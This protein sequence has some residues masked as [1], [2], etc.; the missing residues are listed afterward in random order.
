[1]KSSEIRQKY[2]KYFEGKKHAI[3]P[4]SSLVPDDPSML[5]TTAGMVQFKPYFLGIEKTPYTRI[6]TAQKCL[7]TTDVD[8]VGLTARHLTFFE[9]LGN[10]SF[11]DYY[12]KE[13]ITW[14]WELLTEVFKLDK[15]RLWPTVYVDDDEAFDIWHNVVGVPES[16]IGR[17]KEDNFWSAGPTGPCGPCSEVI[18]D[19]GEEYSCGKDCVIGCDCDRWLEVWNLVFMQSDRDEKG[20]LTDLPKKNIDTGMGLE[21]ISAIL[22]NAK[23]NFETDLL[24]PLVKKI[25]KISGVEYGAG[26]K[27]DISIK[28]VADHSR[29]TAF[30][31]ADGVIPSNDG[32]GYVLRRLIRRA[33]RHGRILGI[34]KPFIVEMLKEVTKMMGSQY[35]ELI[36]HKE[37]LEKIAGTEEQ[38]FLITLKQGLGLLEGKIRELKSKGKKILSGTE[39]FDLYDTY[40]FPVEL[41]REII[42]EENLSIDMKGY[43]KLMEAQKE[44]ARKAWKGKELELEEAYTE[45]FDLVGNTEFIGYKETETEAEVK[46]IVKGKGLSDKAKEGEEVEII[47][48]KTPFYAEKG[49]Q[50]G[51]TGLIS[52]K[53]G[54]FKVTDTKNP[55]SEMIVH[56]G[57]IAVGEVGIGQAARLEIDKERR[58]SIARAHT[59]THL[60]QW[61]LRAV[62][63]EHVKQAGSM[64]EADRLRFDFSH[65]KALTSKEL[66]KVEGL[67]NSR[68]LSSYPVRCYVTTIDYAKE[69]GATALFGE[70]YGKF[71]RVV[72]AGDFSKELCGGTHIKNTG[73]INLFKISSESSIGANIRRIEAVTGRKVLDILQ[74]DEKTI[75]QLANVLKSTPEQVTVKTESLVK[76]LKEKEKEA[77]KVETGD[78]STTVK[79]LAQKAKKV[80]GVAIASAYFK[81]LSLDVLRS[82]T[83]ALRNQLGSSAVI[84]AGGN[85]G[86]VMLITAASK[87]LVEKGFDASVWL[88]KVAPIVKGRGGGKPSLAQAGGTD[89]SKINDALKEAEKFIEQ[90]SKENA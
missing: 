5:L 43:E 49:G 84:L 23:T 8:S 68:I 50:I 19:F 35:P 90:W 64:V 54:V 36:E 69:I 17:L 12:K 39:V 10:F 74:R 3:L 27:T 57:K 24:Y 31:I 56:K 6:T 13:A 33:V 4:S 82:Y 70:K 55:L 87:D 81:G 2:L 65:F 51:D 86:K 42:E 79:E 9:M 77:K 78:F 40:G 21:R 34:E 72:E 47:V 7:R 59:A 76:K 15:K 1:M 11:G 44:K 89:P 28:V 30:L 18:Y 20:K 41:T 66:A 60:L 22:Q 67:V 45:S 85:D 88:N 26:G 29:A 83:D 25:A 52:T 53:T 71:V 73:L 46:A 16:R 62:L 48:N 75:T 80:N 63:G 14:A 38:R 61:A 32:R 37:F 58:Q